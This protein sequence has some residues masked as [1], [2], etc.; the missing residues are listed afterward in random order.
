MGKVRDYTGKVIDSLTVV[1]FIGLRKDSKYKRAY[2][3]CTC[4]CG[5]TTEKSSHYLSIKDT[6]KSCGCYKSSGI[7]KTDIKVQHVGTNDLQTKT[8]SEEKVDGKR[9]V[10]WRCPY[11]SRWV[12]MLDR[13]YGNNHE[14]KYPA[15]K[16]VRVC[17][18]WLKFSN[19]KAWLMVNS[20]NKDL[21]YVHVDK[22]LS[23]FG[24]KLYSP[25]TCVVVDRKINTFLTKDFSGDCLHSTGYDKRT[26]V[27][28]YRSRISNPITKV[29]ENLGLYKSEEE[30]F[31]SWFSRKVEILSDL[32]EY[33][34]CK[35]L[36]PLVYNY[37]K[38]W[39]DNVSI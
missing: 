28:K 14:E 9:V 6:Y 1:N 26:K 34:D 3:N 39:K 16:G 20:K 10:V 33:L 13:C 12:G 38:E 23:L 4:S 35:D 11:Y 19:Y 18:E 27:P 24:N 31:L 5:T 17:E 32:C 21:K 36:Y 8:Q 29:R 37:M 7:K 15:Y 2:W 30:A 22:D 25:D